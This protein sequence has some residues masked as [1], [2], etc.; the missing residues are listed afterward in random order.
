M[1]EIGI[2]IA[3]LVL[4]VGGFAGKVGQV[5]ERR[6]AGFDDGS[7]DREAKRHEETRELI[8]AVK[9]GDRALLREMRDS[10]ASEM[11]ELRAME[12]RQ[13][14]LLAGLAADTRTVVARFQTNGGRFPG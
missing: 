8:V 10:F 6:R 7:E 3:A 9:E 2:A 11:R 5:M 14:E 13:N 12:S 4:L 1:R